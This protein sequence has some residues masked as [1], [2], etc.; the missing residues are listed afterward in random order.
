MVEIEQRH[1]D[2]PIWNIISEVENWGYQSFFLNRNT[3]QLEKLSE[4]VLLR[5][6]D[7]VKNKEL[8]INNIIFIAK[9]R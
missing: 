1:H 8:Y 5:Y 6:H 9:E 2:F 4:D 3:F 7:D